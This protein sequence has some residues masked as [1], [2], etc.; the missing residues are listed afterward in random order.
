MAQEAALARAAD[1]L[2]DRFSSH[3]ETA[4]AA[5]DMLRQAESSPARKAS[6]IGSTPWNAYAFNIDFRTGVLCR[7]SDAEGS[8]SGVRYSGSLPG[9]G[10]G[11][12]QY[13]RG[14]Q[15]SYITSNLCQR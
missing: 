3:R 15:T 4:A 13:S 7:A 11:H 12:G 14:K 6:R 8:V 5:E 1:A 10:L 2:W 9:R